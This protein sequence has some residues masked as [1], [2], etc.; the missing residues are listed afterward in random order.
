MS[1]IYS[2]LSNPQ[3]H[4]P[5]MAKG[6]NIQNTDF[7]LINMIKLAI[8]KL[9]SNNIKLRKAQTAKYPCS[10]CDKNC[11]VDAIFCTHCNKWVHRK[12]NATSKQEYA[13]LSAESD[14]APL[15]FALFYEGNLSDISIF[16]LR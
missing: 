15:M 2:K 1:T 6:H 3:A 8:T 9:K 7:D 14:D 12:C 5:V 13:T 11:M 16:L 10:I 4:D